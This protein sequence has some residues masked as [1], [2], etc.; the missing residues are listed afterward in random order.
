[1]PSQQPRA[2]KLNPRR[3]FRRRLAMVIAPS[4]L[5]LAALPSE[6]ADAPALPVLGTEEPLALAAAPVAEP[7]LTPTAAA[8]SGAAQAPAP[9]PSQN[10]TV[11]LINR[12]VQ[13]GVLAKEDAADLIQQAEADA[14]IARDEAAK[15]AQATQARAA[16]AKPVNDDTVRV[17][18]IPEVVKDEIRDDLRSEVMKQ[19]YEEKWAAPRALPSWVTNLRLFGDFRLRYQ[20]DTFPSGN[21][22][23]GGLP[24]FNKINTGNPY[25][26]TGNNYP[27]EI[28]ADQDRWRLRLRAR[29]GAEADLGEGFTLGGR[30]GTGESNSPVSANQT[31]GGVNSN[32]SNQGGYFSKYS[33]W[34]DRAF[35]KYETPKSLDSFDVSA[36]VGRFD[37]PFFSTSMIWA[38]DLG[39]DGGVLKVRYKGWE[40]I[41]PF[42]TAGGFPVYN[43][44]Y[45]FATNQASKTSSRD[46][47][48]EGFQLGSDIKITH[49]WNAKVAAAYYMY[50][51]V[52]G[53]LSDPF[54]PLSTSD[55]GDTDNLRPTFAQKGN[56]YMALRDIASTSSNNYGDEYQYQYY[57][58]ASKFR[59]VALTGQI[60]YAG[61]DPF[62]IAL[63]GEVVKN[64][65]WNGRD[66]NSNAVNNRGSDKSDG[67]LGDYVGGN[68]GWLVNLNFGHPALEKRWDWNL[69]VGYRYVESDAVIDGFCD[70]DFGGGGTNLKGFTLGGGLGLSK[71]VWVALRWMSAD[72]IAGPTYKEDVIQFDINAKF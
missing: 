72:S 23:T 66:I 15:A 31:M 2:I 49:D 46:K 54:T 25:D 45:S 65:A 36:T 51:N 44:D 27:P 69:N 11:N 14:A 3:Q 29:A 56:T 59:D 38:D 6:A 63:T 4:W 8:S 71:R 32:T 21:D 60:D 9:S 20:G 34:L 30:I 68:L 5:L 7:S 40:R 52:S 22:N 53:K 61:F 17:T 67:S 10:V 64:V 70:S 24:D 48:L 41:T 39:F 35:L 50:Q 47:W 18:Y 62:H 43:T 42:L 26:T 58:L 1:M 19:A 33:I 57:G 37:N 12:L 13:R 55:V 28:N 16:A